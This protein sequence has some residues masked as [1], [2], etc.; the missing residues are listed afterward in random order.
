MIS[1]FHMEAAVFWWR[2][3]VFFQPLLNKCR[4]LFWHVTLILGTTLANTQW[5]HRN[6]CQADLSRC[7]C[8]ISLC[9]V[10]CE[11]RVSCTHCHSRCWILCGRH[12]GMYFILHHMFESVSLNFYS[13][14]RYSTLYSTICL[15]VCLWISTQRCAIVFILHSHSPL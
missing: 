11:W 4:W 10:L 7:H 2:G 1:N 15:K 13:E 9:T 12:T 5:N 14:M 6:W 8:C 3:S